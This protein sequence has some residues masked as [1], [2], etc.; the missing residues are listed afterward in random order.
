MP[1]I[2]LL[3]E[4]K[5]SIKVKGMRHLPNS[6]IITRI[7]SKMFSLDA[8]SV[9]HYKPEVLAAD[10]YT[11]CLELFERRLPIEFAMPT[12]KAISLLSMRMQNIEDAMYVKEMKHEKELS[13]IAI[14]T[15]REIFDIPEYITFFTEINH[16]LD[17]EPQDNSPDSF[18]SLSEQ[19]KAEM[20]DEI[21]KRIILNALVHGSAMHIWKS[22]HYIIQKEIDN[23]SPVLMPFYNE[24][25]A[26]IGWMI[27]QMNPDA[28]QNS[29]A[30]GEAKTQGF[31]KLEFQEQGEPE[32]NIKCS[33][34]NFPVLL[35]EVTKG[36]IDYLICHGIPKHYNEE[37]LKYYY[38][39]SDSYENELWHYLM[40]PTVWIK[41]IES[42]DITT[43]EV[44]LVIARLT[45]LS[46]RELSEVLKACID[47]KESGNLKL[48]EYKIV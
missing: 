16:G 27:W 31:N 11:R 43:Q 18:L 24:Y 46:Y 40:S 41:L 3:K 8:N 5:F 26:V 35:H 12:G 38:A 19:D 28:F 39:K 47:G 4:K 17:V 33:A 23:I 37:Q 42:A 22:A 44:P 9:F 32:C 30:N 36:A 34:I 6:G 10:E 13:K 1:S 25:T 20:R 48:I 29:I 7:D 14:S 45:K 15:I 21:Q 2:D